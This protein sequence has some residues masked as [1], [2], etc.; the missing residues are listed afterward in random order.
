VPSRCPF[1]KADPGVRPM[2]GV[3]FGGNAPT[4]QG[5]VDTSGP[6]T[7]RAEAKRTPCVALVTLVRGFVFGGLR[8]M[9]CPASWLGQAS[10]LFCAST[11]A[12]RPRGAW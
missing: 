5:G 8:W 11:N 2:P 1:A 6:G 7:R 4:S 9:G 3:G 12:M 10:G